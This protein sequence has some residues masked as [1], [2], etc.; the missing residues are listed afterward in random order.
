MS[1]ELL[2]HLKNVNTN[3]LIGL[4]IQQMLQQEEGLQ[5][6]LQELKSISKENPAVMIP[7][8]GWE[9]HALLIR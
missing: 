5:K 6:L 3:S 2:N 1:D 9:A 4:C 8:I 7:I